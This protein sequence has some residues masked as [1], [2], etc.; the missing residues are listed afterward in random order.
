[1]AAKTGL[2][3]KTNVPH[4]LAGGTVVGKSLPASLGSVL[5]LRFVF[6]VCF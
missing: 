5:G 2:L 1:M 4:G 3:W 6:V